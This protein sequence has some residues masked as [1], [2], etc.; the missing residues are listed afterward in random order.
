MAELYARLKPYNPK[1][2]YKLR[3]YTVFSIRFHVDRGWYK[4]APDVAAYLK[5]VHQDNNNPDSPLAFDVCTA[6]EVE[7]I[8]K[9]ERME[10]IRR[11]EIPSPLETA[12]D[13]TA[14]AKDKRDRIA[15]T[16]SKADPVGNDLT[17][18]DLPS[19]VAGGEIAAAM[20]DVQDQDPIATDPVAAEPLQATDPVDTLP[21]H[22]PKPTPED[23]EPTNE[24][25]P[26]PANPRRRSKKKS[27]KKKKT[28]AKE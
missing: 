24:P 26:A 28:T 18:A 9:R 13:T 21:S 15:A 11:G 2:G 3:R 16:R 19:P 5:T 27:T 7:A 10:K 1:R 22:P 4:I 12:H 8:A 17:T 25:S 6:A 20:N 14:E 23:P